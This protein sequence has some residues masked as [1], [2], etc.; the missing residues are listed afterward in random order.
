MPLTTLAG[1]QDRPQSVAPP[2]ATRGMLQM[3]GS[4]HP[5]RP[6]APARRVGIAHHPR[7]FSPTAIS[8]CC[9]INLF[10]N[11]CDR[12]M[13]V[14]PPGAISIIHE[15]PGLD[16]MVMMSIMSIMSIGHNE[17]VIIFIESEGQMFGVLMDTNVS[18]SDFKERPDNIL[19][20]RC[21]SMRNFGAVA[22]GDQ[23]RH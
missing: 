3:V 4:A 15:K 11:V 20:C 21:T 17:S 8:T 13:C 9:P 23:N 1:D 10:I 22:A 6:C 5:T 16:I 12:A 7:T 14:A 19:C 18:S 2:Q